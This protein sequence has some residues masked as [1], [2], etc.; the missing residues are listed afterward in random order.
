MM[1]VL[2]TKQEYSRSTD[3]TPTPCHL[4]D[5]LPLSYT[6]TG[7]QLQGK[8]WGLGAEELEVE[9]WKSVQ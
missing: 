5:T 6:G 1:I 4:S 8:S 3:P 2:K 9:R 7:R